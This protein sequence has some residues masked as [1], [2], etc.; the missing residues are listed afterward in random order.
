MGYIDGSNAVTMRITEDVTEIW[1]NILKGQKVTLWCDRLKSKNACS[2]KGTL[3]EQSN[4]DE[5]LPEATR[6]ENGG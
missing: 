5:A 4:E 6:K 3:S 2:G 1:I